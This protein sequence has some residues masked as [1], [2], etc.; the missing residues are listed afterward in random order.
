LHWLSYFTAFCFTVFCFVF[1]PPLNQHTCARAPAHTRTPDFNL[2]FTHN[3][4]Q[5]FLWLQGFIY[6]A[7]SLLVCFYSK[8]MDPLSYIT[9]FFSNYLFF[10]PEMEAAC[11]SQV[12]L[13]ICQSIGCHVTENSNLYSCYL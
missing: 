5:L 10:F 2:C 13:F 4:L 7:H 9:D 3:Y 6:F 1:A 8:S 11:F 12:P